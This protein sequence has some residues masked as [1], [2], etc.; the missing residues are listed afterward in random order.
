MNPKRRSSEEHEVGPAQLEPF[1]RQAE[2]LHMLRISRPTLWTWRRNPKVGFPAAIRLGGNT[3]VWRRSDV[4]RW[5]ST[6]P[7]A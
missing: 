7:A 5:L 6:R 2:L 3:I 4:E 1:Y